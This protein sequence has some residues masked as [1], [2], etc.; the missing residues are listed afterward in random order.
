MNICLRSCFCRRRNEDF[1]Y[2]FHCGVR[3]SV[4]TGLEAA[5]PQLLT[6]EDGPTDHLSCTY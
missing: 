3:R 4:Y 2:H 6:A 5:L 1:Y